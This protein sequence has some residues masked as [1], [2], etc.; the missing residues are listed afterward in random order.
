MQQI[1]WPNA[2]LRAAKAG[3]IDS[4]SHF[5]LQAGSYKFPFRLRLPI[6][7]SC[8]PPPSAMSM[9]HYHISNGGGISTVA[10]PTTHVKQTLPPSLGGIEDAWI[11]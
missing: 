1:V 4:S 11:R 6:N 7:N 3:N 8:Q 9:Q 10:H 5:T 2:E